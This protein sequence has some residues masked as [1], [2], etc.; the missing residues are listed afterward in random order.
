ME[1]ILL[2]AHILIAS[3]SPDAISTS[4]GGDTSNTGTI[5]DKG[6]ENESADY[7]INNDIMP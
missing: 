2:L 3:I 5:I 6:G 4:D 7:I 1:L